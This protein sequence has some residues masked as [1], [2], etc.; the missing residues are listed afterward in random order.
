M[1]PAPTN[2]IFL[3]MRSSGVVRA[4]G[5]GGF[6][7]RRG[8]ATDSG[9]SAGHYRASGARSPIPA[10]R[11]QLQQ[12]GKAAGATGELTGRAFLYDRALFQDDDPVGFH[13]G[14]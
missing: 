8:A 1:A 9:S 7:A 4:A 3:A 14:R 6:P 10:G 12:G 2:R 5:G 11:L 13:G